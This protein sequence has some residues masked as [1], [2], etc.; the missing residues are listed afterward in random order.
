MDKMNLQDL[1]L[2][3]VNGSLRKTLWT[4]TAIVGFFFVGLGG[5]SAHAPLAGAAIAPA[6]ISPD[7]ERR[8]VQHL[9]GGIV[10][11][12]LVQEGS[13]VTVGQAL[14]TMDSS[15][16]R[17]TRDVLM[18][19]LRSNLAIRARL[20]AERDSVDTVT[21]PDEIAEGELSAETTALISSQ[22]ALFESRL[23]AREQKK[24]ILLEQ[25]SQYDQ[26]MIG[27]TAQIDS[28]TKQLSLVREELVGVA[29]LVEKG[30]ERKPRL[31]GLQRAEA[32]ILGSRANNQAT[33]AK[34]R[35]SISETR[36]QIEGIETEHKQDV[37]QKLA[38][39]EAAISA[40]REK[41][42]AAS[43][44]VD[45][46]TVTSP[47]SGTVV[48][49]K[50]NTIGGV[51]KAGDTILEIVPSD[52][53]LL[54]DA[55]IS[56]TDIDEVRPGLGAR[57]VM[58]SYAQRNMPPLMGRVRQVSADRLMDPRS[59][60]PYYQARIELPVE[61]VREVAPNVNLKPGMPAEVMVM[62]GERTL[63]EYLVEPLMAS[64]RKSFREN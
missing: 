56:P 33:L 53:E 57:V 38:E 43:F 55:R 28:Q 63:L 4:G 47:V 45:R 20:I 9:E 59:G 29:Q 7:G 23:K 26:V 8:A 37:G 10:K 14:V 35:Q 18:K 51:V 11:E 50:A 5:W 54:V 25:I 44:I 19:D 64:M 42:G 31:L 60:Q 2:G 39:A 6:V 34:T 17:A 58:T 40:I 52:E 62:T 1:Q 27:L 22:Q 12:L 24:K 41:L 48:Q 13:A 32:E 15:A 46:T 21:F 3:M 49:L 36:A 61:H 16:S 30:L